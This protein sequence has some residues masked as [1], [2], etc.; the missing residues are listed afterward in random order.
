[1]VWTEPLD[2]TGRSRSRGGGLTGMV[3]VVGNLGI[4][5]SDT[6]SVICGIFG[7]DALDYLSDIAAGV[8]LCLGVT[9]TESATVCG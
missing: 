3:V 1:M 6:P 8:C 9:A 5:M 7:F 2:R 4:V